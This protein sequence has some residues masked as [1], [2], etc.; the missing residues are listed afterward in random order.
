M[1][2]TMKT[3]MLI[4]CLIGACGDPKVYG[5]CESA[6]DCTG[7]RGDGAAQCLLVADV[8]VCAWSCQVD[9]DCGS[10]DGYKRL[11]AAP[12][13]GAAGLGNSCLPSCEDADVAGRADVCPDGYTCRST[14]AG[15]DIKKACFPGK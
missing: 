10:D 1:R 9:A 5:G 4:L 3:W 6:A 14:G 7:V 13:E 8:K 2:E 15:A 12:P 11:C